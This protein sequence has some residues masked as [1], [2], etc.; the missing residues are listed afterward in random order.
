MEQYGLGIRLTPG[1]YRDF[2]RNK[3]HKKQI[4]ENLFMAV[5]RAML[6]DKCFDVLVRKPMQDS[7]DPYLHN[8]SVGIKITVER[9]I[10]V[11]KVEAKKCL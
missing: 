9:P 1:A 11:I 4:I 3:K 7:P 10:G 6:K 8:G 5:C 2:K